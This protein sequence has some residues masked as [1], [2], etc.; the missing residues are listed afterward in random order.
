[1]S[2]KN[3]RHLLHFVDEDLFSFRNAFRL[4]LTP[5]LFGFWLF[6][7][8]GVLRTQAPH[9]LSSCFCFFVFLCYFLS[10]RV[11]G[12]DGIVRFRQ[13]TADFVNLL[14]HAG[15]CVCVCVYVCVLCPLSALAC[16]TLVLSG[17]LLF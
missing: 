10:A 12:F 16:W 7:H 17:R 1:M 13:F 2:G 6:E 15:V 5:C 4:R 9:S 8:Y 11:S 14:L 3:T